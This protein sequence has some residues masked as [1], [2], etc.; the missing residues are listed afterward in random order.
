MN[1]TPGFDFDEE[2]AAAIVGLLQKSV[3]LLEDTV[4]YADRSCDE[5]TVLPYKKCIAGIVFDLGWEVL[6][7]GFYK[8]YPQLRPKESSLRE[9]P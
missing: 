3:R 4:A 2:H 1:E 7:Q 5:E 8:R 9:Q 6:E